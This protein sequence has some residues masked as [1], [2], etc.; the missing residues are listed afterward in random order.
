MA[1]PDKKRDKN[2]DGVKK[3]CKKYARAITDYVLNQQTDIPKEELFQHLKECAK[4]H[5]EFSDWKDFND[6]VRVKE[7]HSRPEVKEKWDKFIT[8]LV[9]S[10]GAPAKPSQCSTAVIPGATVV[11]VKWEIGNAAGVI[12]KHLSTAGIT[13]LNDI[14]GKTSIPMETALQAI[15][16]LAREEK[17]CKER[18]K[19]TSYVYV[20]EHK[21]AQG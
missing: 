14:P 8:E 18:V 4:C 1:T 9:H 19:T 2:S 13:K 21:Q 16:W 12:Y 15:G 11:D 20:P 17:V 6:F 3:T 10:G 5:K 7:Y